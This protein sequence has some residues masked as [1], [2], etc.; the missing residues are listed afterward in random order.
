M[1]SAFGVRDFKTHEQA[2]CIQHV[3][4]SKIRRLHRSRRIGLRSCKAIIER[5]EKK[6]RQRG[7][8]RGVPNVRKISLNDPAKTG[9][10]SNNTHVKERVQFEKNR[11]SLAADNPR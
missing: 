10:Q 3:I 7:N 8:D 11:K 1:K 4:E 6:Q 9:N 5:K 2:S